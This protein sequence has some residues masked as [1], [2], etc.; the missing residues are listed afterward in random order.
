MKFRTIFS[1][2]LGGFALTA[3]A[4]GG[5]QDGVDYYNADRFE[6]AKTILEKTLND[7]STDKA[8][9]YFY[10][11]SLD[12]REGNTA[13]AAANFNKGKEANPNYGYNYVGLGEIAL[14]NGNKSEASDLFKKALETNKKDASLMAAV[15]RAYF[16]VDPTLYAKEIDKQI[17]KAMKVSKN[18]EAQIY[19][20]QGD[21]LKTTDVGAAA[22]RYEQAMVY[23]EEAGNI[24]PEAYVKYANLYN[25]VNPDFAIAKLV[26]L[27]E[28]LPN[29]A[30]AQSELAEKYYDGNQF[31]KAA[32]QYGKYIQNPN[33][34]QGDEQR[35]SGLLYFGKKY[36]E[37]LDVA[38]QVLAKDPNN[39]YMQRMVMLN[40]A[41]LKDFTG[42]EEAAKKLFSHAD[43]KFTATD[44]TTYGDILGELKRPEDAVAAYTKA[45]EL[46]P[47]K[48]K[49]ILANISSMYT[50]LEDY[51]KA[52]EYMQKF[53]DA[54][55]ASLND[56]FILS[57]RYK[58]LGVSL[59]EGSPER[60]EAAN[61]GIKYVDMAIESAAN[62]GPLYRNKATLMMV[63]DGA[64]I[65][66][67]LVETYQQ[68]LAAYDENPENKEKYRDA[69]KSAY[70]N[71]ANYYLKAGDKEQ[72][73][74]YFEKFLEIDPENE[75]LREYLNK[76]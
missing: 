52:A 30:L 75:A 25:K 46:N 51:Q 53:V 61:N 36:Q 66:P 19:V 63:R 58:N 74:A 71:L 20:L 18:K 21:M 56:Y 49:Q 55:D 69:Y 60:I 35:Y 72:A 33:H 57:N 50:D 23:D 65:T 26:E 47:E 4:Q 41:A 62:K 24:N 27:N 43:A 22:G 37:S 16:N 1:L 28:K 73:R 70:N 6:K 42:A 29:S 38:N 14:K 7:P 68:M 15:A 34:F 10:L 3:F 31:T 32:E 64:E 40:K 2:V 44:Y 67:A 45:Y 48:N 39:E 11:G 59:P 54:G 13:A 8:V 17:D 12:M 76:M 9:S 5:Y